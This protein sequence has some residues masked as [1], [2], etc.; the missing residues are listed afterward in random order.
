MSINTT[1]NH[2]MEILIRHVKSHCQNKG[3]SQ[4]DVI[5]RLVPSYTWKIKILVKSFKASGNYVNIFFYRWKHLNDLFWFFW[6]K[7]AVAGIKA[8]NRFNHRT[9]LLWW[10]NKLWRSNFTI[11]NSVIL[12]SSFINPYQGFSVVRRLKIYKSIQLK[13]YSLWIML[14]ISNHSSLSQL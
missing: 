11:F 9:R 2:W 5:E 6:S 3:D 1:T 4:F 14:Y 8:L 12:S 10:R 13:F 7:L